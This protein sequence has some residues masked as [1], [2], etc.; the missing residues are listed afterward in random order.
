MS[1]RDCKSG[2]TGGKDGTGMNKEYSLEEN[3]QHGTKERPLTIMNF[4]TGKGTSYPDH[5]FVERHWHYNTEILKIRKGRYKAEINLETLYL[6]EGDICMIN[7]GELH[8]L[9]G[10]GSHTLHDA[11]IYNQSIL[12]F[13]YEDEMQEKLIHP[14]LSHKLV[15][16]RIIHPSD[17][18]YKQLNHRVEHLIEL[19]EKKTDD[20]YFQLKLEILQFLIDLNRYGLFISSADTATA[21]EKE[22]IDRY[23][24]IV[25]LIEDNY[26]SALTLQML[27]QAAG[28]NPQYLCR[29]FKEIAGI[30]P[31]QYLIR[32]RIQQAERLL[33][34]TTKTILEISLD[35]GFDNVSYF[36]RQFKKQNGLTPNEYRKRCHLDLFQ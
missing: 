5:F 14:L 27:A 16:P 26:T 33:G 11:L 17:T 31:I 23:K 22:R 15:L 19:G 32:Y 20:W 8:L 13:S 6:Q 25:S 24:R 36:I 28:C 10:I 1:F 2:G 4:C 18:G 7:S 29:F 34:N 3:V 9:E 35:S 21:F 30:S 12:R